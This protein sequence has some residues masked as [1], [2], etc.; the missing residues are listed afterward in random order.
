MKRWCLLLFF[1]TTVAFAQDSKQVTEVQKYHLQALNAKITTVQTQLT[2]L[3]VQFERLQGDLQRIQQERQTLI[4]QIYKTAGLSRS[5]WSLNETT[6][7]FER[8]NNPETST[9]RP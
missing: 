8:I 7:N 2:L 1:L 5:E 6:G 3:Q 9:P 4:E